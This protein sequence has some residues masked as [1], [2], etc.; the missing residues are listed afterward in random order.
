MVAQLRLIN[1]QI[2]DA[3]RR[4][5]EFCAAIEASAQGQICEQ[6][7]VAILRSCPGLGRINI[8]TLL[9]EASEALR[10]A[11]L[12]RPAGDVRAKPQ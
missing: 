2:N 9:G 11:R 1:Q 8:A 6:R 3:E 5:D 7:D 10:P 4:L 12:P